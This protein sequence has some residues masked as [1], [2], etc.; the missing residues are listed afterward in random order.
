[1]TL[2]LKI[3]NFLEKDET[4]NC[5]QTTQLRI[6]ACKKRKEILNDKANG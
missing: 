3:G 6:N 4:Q 2:R 5:L 1:M